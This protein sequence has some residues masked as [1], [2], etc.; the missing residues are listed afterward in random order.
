MKCDYTSAAANQHGYHN[1][2]WDG[3]KRLRKRFK[4]VDKS[5][6]HVVPAPSSTHSGAG[7]SGDK[8]E[9]QSLEAGKMRKTLNF[10]SFSFD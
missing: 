7:P 8:G 2:F 4:H 6:A 9:S 1:G 10:I 3:C 5:A